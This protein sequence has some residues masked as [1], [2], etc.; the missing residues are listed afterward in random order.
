MERDDWRNLGFH[1]DPQDKGKEDSSNRKWS[2]CF[3]FFPDKCE[4]VTLQTFISVNNC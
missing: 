4:N 2:I 3:S 1:N